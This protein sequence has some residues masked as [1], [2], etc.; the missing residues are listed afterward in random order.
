MDIHRTFG[1]AVIWENG[2]TRHEGRVEMTRTALEGFG[3]QLKKTDEV[4]IE[5]TGNCM[6]VS[7][8]LSPYVKRVVIA[9][10]LQVKAIAHAHVK[11]DKVDAGTLASLHAAG[12]LPEIWTP[13]AATE[14]M[15]RLVARRYQVVRHRT[16]I[17]NE[18]HAI[19]HA[20]LIPKCPHADLF[21]KRGRDW[22]A[23]QPVPEDE[24]AAIARHIRELDRLGEDLAQL[25]RGIAQDSLDDKE[26]QR[27]LTITG[28]NLTVAAGL[29]AAIGSIERFKSPQK[30][31]S[32]FGL[33]PRVRQS[34]LGPAHHGRISKAGRS[35]ARAM[36]VE[37]AWAAA[38]APGPLR[39]FFIRIRA[40]RG[41]QIAAVAVARKLAALCW[42]MLTKGE[43]YRWARPSLVAHKRR[44]MELA[45]GQP[46]KKGNRRGASYAYNVKDLRHQEAKIAEQ[47]EKSYEHFVAAWRPHPP[48]QGGCAAASNRQGLNRLPGDAS[49]RR[50]TL[51]PEVNRTA[52]E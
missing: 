39:A 41:H 34:G 35:H 33:N 28:V 11:T 22:L 46:Q 29:M 42:H 9:N 49:S 3:R 44:A 16:R 37:A 40:R 1:E 47:A 38:K 48:K 20:H 25:D 30:L 52:E 13:D 31:V 2:L 12:Y 36:L 45:A 6:A 23:R 17:K 14:R 24:R 27:L 19:L 8:I 50:A 26:I 7:R 43:D 32:Y 15:R 4:V 21:N 5:A 18:V 51:R 10:P